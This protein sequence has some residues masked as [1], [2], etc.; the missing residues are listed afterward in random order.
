MAATAVQAW[1]ERWATPEGRADWQVPDPAVWR[2]EVGRRQ[3][4]H[5]EFTSRA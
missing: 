1:G 3:R 2:R 4:D 5:Q